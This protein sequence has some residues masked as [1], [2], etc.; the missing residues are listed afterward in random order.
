MS[1]TIINGTSNIMITVV[2]II[3]ITTTVILENKLF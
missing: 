3:I 2:I 1:N